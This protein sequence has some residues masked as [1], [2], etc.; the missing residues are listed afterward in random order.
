MPDTLAAPPTEKPDISPTPPAEDT[1]PTP[2]TPDDAPPLAAEGE[3]N[4]GEVQYDLT[5]PENSTLDPAAVERT[6]AYARERGLTPEQAQ[7]ALELASQEA[8]TALE[9]RL[10]AFQPGGAEHARIV[11][12]WKTETLADPVLGATPEERTAAIQK[13]H[14][15]VEK[16]RQH[17]PEH[18][19]AFV[20]MLND[21]GYGNH[22]DVAR[23]FAWLGRTASESPLIF[24]THA[25][26]AKPTPQKFYPG[27]NP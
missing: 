8:T 12:G 20:G 4:A 5:L 13:G 6:V 11:E 14:L 1:P 25:P 15:V 21:S 22:R 23:F 3:P 24:G 7:A 26:T 16:Y 27:M 9:A 10:A 19:D 2:P 18:A 17:N